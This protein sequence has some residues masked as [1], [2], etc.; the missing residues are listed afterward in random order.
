MG[1][2]LALARLHV[3]PQIAEAADLVLPSKLSNMLSS[4]R[5]VVATA[6]PGTGVACEIEGCGLITPPGDAAALAGAIARL[7]DDPQLADKMG[8]NGIV[9]ARTLEPRQ[10]TFRAGG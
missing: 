7:V 8:Q 4:G 5:P 3:L 6:A 9:R 10:D 1:G 2:L